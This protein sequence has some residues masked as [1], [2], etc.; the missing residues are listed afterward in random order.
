MNKSNIPEYFNSKINPIKKRPQ[1]IWFFSLLWLSILSGIAFFWHLGDI[2]LV[3]KTEPMFVEAS[4]QMVVTGDWITP[5][6][7]GETRFDK[8]P[9]TYWLSGIAFQIFGINEGAARLPAALLA[10]ALVALGFY[11]LRRFGCLPST[12]EASDK[13]LWLSAWIGAGILAFNPAWIAWGRTGVSDMPLASTMSLSLLCFFCGY[14]QP[15][16]PKAQ[17]YW[18]LA[19]S[20]FAA[21]AVL[22][23]GPIGIILPG[24]IIV[25]FGL[26]LGNWRQLL[27][28]IPWLVASLLFV[29]IAVPWFI[30]VT[31]A[32]GQAYIDSFFGLHNFQRFTSVVSNH[33]GPWYYFIPVLLVGFFPWSLYLPVT[34]AHLGFWRRKR[35][36]SA[37]RSQH[38]GIFALF[39]LTI[40]FVFFSISVTK[41]PSYIL[42]A[43]PAAGIMVALFWGEKMAVAPSRPSQSLGVTAIVN[44]L[45]LV[46]LAVAAFL[47]P[48]LIREDPVIPG[49]PSALQASGLPWQTALIWGI[50]A[51]T[52]VWLLLRRRWWR[53][54]WLPNL[55]GLMA[56]IGLIAWPAS[57]LMDSY[58]QLPLRQLSAR[59]VQVRQPQEELFLIGFIRPSVVYYTQ[60]PVKFFYDA[61]VIVSY[62]EE[63]SKNAQEVPTVLLM[64]EERLMPKLGLSPQDYEDLGMRGG[65][66]LIRV[67]KQFLLQKLTNL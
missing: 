44:V 34:V 4:R 54:L 63:T 11:T 9:L 56:F 33:P 66:R 47:S 37:P 24:M 64:L 62:L 50:A 28:E 31:A 17:R 26:Y 60:Q 6:W 14:A 58:R 52:A 1:L 5:Y 29:A 2:G 23:K 16:K 15:E 3:D 53:W 32:N 43:I 7:N 59:V 41:L 12:S 8:P 22:A 51:I 20:V 67:N 65:Y 40:I 39:W 61:P 21:L 25:A 57:A 36:Q 49:F 30:A 45:L 13:Q 46:A 10:T 27:V 55:W 18:Y 19:F 42:P 38:L 35:W 48:R